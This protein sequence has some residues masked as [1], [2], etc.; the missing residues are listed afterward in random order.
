MD[1]RFLFPAVA[2]TAWA[3][4]ANPAA[5][6]AEK[7]LRERVEKYYQLAVEKKYREAE[8]FVA[9]DTRDE[10]YNGAKPNVKGFTIEKIELADNN[11][12]A[13]VTIKAR[14]TLVMMGAGAHDFDAPAISTWKLE[15]GKWVMY[16]DP[17]AKMQTPWGKLNPALVAGKG[18]DSGVVAPP[19][20]DQLLKAVSIDKK[21][22]IL[23]VASPEQAVVV[24]NNLPGPVDLSLEMPSG[25]QGLAAAFEK[26]HLESG[27]K[28]SLK[29]RSTEQ[30]S[31]AGVI[32]VTVAPLN[33]ELEIVVTSIAK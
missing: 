27:E 26:T 33:Q 21:D 4:Q 25:I 13:T 16:I 30:K 12:R 24:S 7:A 18:P 10:Y 15:R 17:E 32:R 22:V 5:A 20:V 2:A 8:T 9:A 6:R 3:Q 29:I 19:Q 31:F 14:V 23:T 1:R 11:K 28:T